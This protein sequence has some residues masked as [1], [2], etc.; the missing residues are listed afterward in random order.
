MDQSTKD[1]I[2]QMGKSVEQVEAQLERFKN[3]FPYLDIKKPA[4]VGDGIIKLATT[5]LDQFISFYENRSKEYE[6]VKFVPASGAASRMFKRLFEF[7][8]EEESKAEQDDFLK[9]FFAG[10]HDFA[11]ADD[12]NRVLEESGTSLDQALKDKQYHLIVKSLLTEE[13]LNYGQ[14]PKGLLAF[15]QYGKISKTPTGEHFTEGENYA[16][17]KDGVVHLHFTVSP[18]H[19]ELF[20]KEVDHV[21][22]GLSKYEVSFSQQ[23]PATDTIAADM[24]NAPFEEEGELLFRPAGH[25]ALIENL[26]KVDADIVFI[27]N[28]DNV[29][30]DHLKELTIRYKKGLGGLLMSVQNQVFSHLEKLERNINEIELL[31]VEEFARKELMLSFKDDYGD[32]PFAEKVGYLQYLLHRPIRVCG[33]VPNTGEPGGGPFWVKEGDGSYSLQIVETSQFNPENP[34]AMEVLKSSTHF[35]PVDL[36]CAFRDYAGRKFDLSKYVDAETGFIT[37]KSKNGR[38]L[39]ALELPGLWNGAMSNWITLFVE[40]PIETFNPVKTVNDLLREQ[41]QGI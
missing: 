6:I 26:N 16:K 7:L 1:K 25:G 21:R 36:I 13:G 34:A 27:K 32:L 4:T 23:D 28:I 14:L 8:S 35:N 19:Q 24:N 30:P 31:E 41:H 29:V 38:S 15:H 10:M 39:Q 33:M 37:E 11:F 40:V 3:G 9:K 2:V 12:L 22:R 17:G 20:E 18:E 5:S